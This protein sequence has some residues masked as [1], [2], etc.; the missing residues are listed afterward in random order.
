MSISTVR[1]VRTLRRLRADRGGV[2]SLELGIV[3]SLI[4]LAALQGLSLLGDEV[5]S[6]VSETARAVAEKR[7]ER[8]D[9]FARAA[10]GN[11]ISPQTETEEPTE[12]PVAA[13][14]TYTDYPAEPPPAMMAP[15]QP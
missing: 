6:D 13:A 7:A 5:D 12:P 9:P 3:A 14:Q 4:A 8:A 11:R 2:S 10:N 1:I 15:P